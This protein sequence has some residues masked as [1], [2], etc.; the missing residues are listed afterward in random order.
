MTAA[1]QLVGAVALLGTGAIYGFDVFAALVLRSALAE[2]DDRALTEVMGQV[3]RYGDR[4]LAIPSALGLIATGVAVVVSALAGSGAAAVASGVAFGAQALWLAV[5]GRVSVPVNRQLTEA[6]RAGRVP[7]DTRQLQGRWD[8]AI[9]IR[10][11]LQVVAVVALCTA[12][13]LA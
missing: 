1:S 12:L 4:R 13:A 8:R 3:H 10:L 6:A 2:V 7:P 9:G 11:P 5:Y